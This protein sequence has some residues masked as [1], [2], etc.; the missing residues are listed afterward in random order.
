[1]DIFTGIDFR[2]YSESRREKIRKEV[3]GEPVDRLLGMDE[4]EYV[5]YLT[6]KYSID[7]IVFDMT[8]KTATEREAQIPA[9]QFPNGFYVSPGGRYPKNVITLHVPYKGNDALLRVR[10]STFFSRP[11]DVGASPGKIEVDVIDFYNDGVRIKDAIVHICSR[12]EQE[13]AYLNQDVQGWNSTLQHQVQQIVEKCKRDGLVRKNSLSSIGVPLLAHA[14]VPASFLVPAKSKTID[15]Q[16]PAAALGSY[17][18]DPRY[19]DP[20]YENILRIVYDTGLSLE[21]SPALHT[22][23]TE[24]GI[25]DYLLMVLSTHYRNASAET[26]RQSGKTDILV[27]YKDDKH[28][29]VLFVAEVKVWSGQV[30]LTKA[31]TQLLSYLTWRDSRAALILLVRNQGA[32][33]VVN[34]VAG[35]VQTH[36]QWSSDCPGS[37]P[38]SRYSFKLSLPTDPSRKVLLCVMVFHLPEIQLKRTQRKKP[39]EP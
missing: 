2:E 27:P 18:P 16:K 8:N 3:A 1:M 39:V 34:Q 33:A 11:L 4:K 31:I 15:P 32:D 35:I 25:R 20:D 12:L 37:E 6:S 30:S 17:L 7:P 36:P 19:S 21:R 13:S 26:F 10:P 23:Q 29:G 14:A 24:E 9:E 5:S 38:Y 22:T 28:E